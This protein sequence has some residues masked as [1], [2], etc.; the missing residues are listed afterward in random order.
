MIDVGDHRHVADVVLEVHLL[1]QLIDGKLRE[2]HE[3]AKEKFTEKTLA[4]RLGSREMH[5]EPSAESGETREE[6]PDRRPARRHETL[7]QS[8]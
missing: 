3:D 1:A 8:L 6:K 2:E 4:I 5:G 7:P